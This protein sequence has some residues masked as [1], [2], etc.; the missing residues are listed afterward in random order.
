MKAPAWAAG[1]LAALLM[2]GPPANAASVEHG[3]QIVQRN[4]AICHAVG[5]R[6][7]STNREAPPFRDLHARYPVEMLAEALAEGILTG[8]PAMPQFVFP[9]RDIDDIIAYLQSIQTRG[10]AGAGVRARAG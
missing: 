1:A 7:R 9:A 4:C 10:N 5:P 2:P 3:R 8:H 6:G